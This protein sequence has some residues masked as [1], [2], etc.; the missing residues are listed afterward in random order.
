MAPYHHGDLRRSL[1]DAALELLTEEQNWMF[2]LREVAR[3]AGVSHNAPYNHFAD[4]KELLA[5]VAALGFETL[6]KKMLAAIVGVHR[7]D[8][9][10]EKT[11]VVYIR[12]GLDNPAHYRLMFG[13]ELGIDDADR[14]HV[15]VRAA[16]DAKAVLFGIIERGASSG[17][18]PGLDDSQKTLV[19]ALAAW[20]TAHGF[21]ML[22][23][24]GRAGVLPR[25]AALAAAEQICHTITRG[26]TKN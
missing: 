11:G 22:L 24:D 5:E 2:S 3:R 20:S 6:R 4:K 25:R 16:D 18:F 26:L 1:V 14:P 15:V 19:A 21:T 9:A 17:T 8:A 12:F 7:S 23:L 10:L 13:A